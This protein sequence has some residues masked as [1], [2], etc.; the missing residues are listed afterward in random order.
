[1]VKQA[2]S[3]RKGKNFSQDKLISF[4]SPPSRKCNHRLIFDLTITLL[5]FYDDVGGGERQ[6][7]AIVQQMS[8]QPSPSLLLHVRTHSYFS[9]GVSYIM[10]AVTHSSSCLVRRKKDIIRRIIHHS[11]WT[12][13]V[14][15]NGRSP[16]SSF[17]T[18][19]LGGRCCSW[20]APFPFWHPRSV[21]GVLGCR[22][23]CRK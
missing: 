3:F 20:L 8:T 23:F 7:R 11:N 22:K 16:S 21:K 19:F 4:L 17:F 9:P 5:S 13:V 10:F 2:T 18:A 1:M 15:V 14:C 12:W 6:L